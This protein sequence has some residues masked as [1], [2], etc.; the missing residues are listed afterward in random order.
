MCA[1]QSSRRKA[2]TPVAQGRDQVGQPTVVDVH[3]FE[4]VRL[5]AWECWRL[6][7]WK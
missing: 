4:L 7:N 6:L 1:V 3:V 2:W 5:A